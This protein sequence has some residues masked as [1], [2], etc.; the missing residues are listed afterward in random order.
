V[1]APTFDLAH[2]EMIA[3]EASLNCGAQHWSEGAGTVGYHFRRLGCALP[4]AVVL[5][6]CARL[7]W[8]ERLEAA[9]DEHLYNWGANEEHN[10]LRAVLA[11][12]PR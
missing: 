11:E 3:R 4:P 10:A 5:A 8:A 9:V 1:T 2:V 7:R 6:M 12:R